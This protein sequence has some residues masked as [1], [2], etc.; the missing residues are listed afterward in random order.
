MDS[1]EALVELSHSTAEAVCGV[2]RAFC[3]DGLEMGSVVVVPNGSNPLAT[4]RPPIMTADVS[5]AQ[6][7]SGGNLLAV[8]MPGARKLAAAMTDESD[9]D[10]G[11]LSEVALAAVTEAM[12]QMMAAAAKATGALLGAGVGSDPP[13]IRTVDSA[14][15]ALADIQQNVHITSVT[16]ELDGEL[17]RLVQIVPKTFTVRMTAQA[18]P[19]FD[20]VPLAVPPIVTEVMP[21]PA[22][23]EALRDV[24][25]R[26]WG[27]LGRT[28]MVA[29]H[30]VSLGPGAV[31]DLDR[32]VEDPVDLYVNG[33]RFGTGRLT[34]DGE[35]Q[36]TVEI[37][38]LEPRENLNLEVS[39]AQFSRRSATG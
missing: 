25:L 22:I 27:E 15:A 13:Q 19:E 8:T 30:A 38:S 33:C 9:V 28:R 32:A 37:T 1:Q 16:F 24:K 4:M 36:W 18:D 39:G 6:G 26:V 29:S 3:G 14:D 34:V 17:C 10:A 2:L 23:S 12:N 31:V 20:D 35:E 11:E 7:V 5:Y 21:D